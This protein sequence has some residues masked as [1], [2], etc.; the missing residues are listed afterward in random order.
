MFA[1]LVAPDRVHIT[2][3]DMPL[4]ANIILHEKAFDFTPYYILGDFGG[5]KWRLYCNDNNRIDES[6]IIHNKIEMFFYG[7]RVAAMNLTVRVDR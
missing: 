2:A 7:V 4:G 6:G 3:D 5:R 1:E